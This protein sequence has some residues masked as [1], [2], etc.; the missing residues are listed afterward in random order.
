MHIF[1]PL[2][3]W[4]ENDL[5]RKCWRQTQLGKKNISD[6]LEMSVDEA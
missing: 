4:E 6:V 2:R 5:N 3:V 1:D